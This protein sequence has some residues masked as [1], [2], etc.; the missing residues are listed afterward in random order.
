[1][2]LKKSNQLNILQMTIVILEQ[3]LIKIQI[4]GMKIMFLIIF[5]V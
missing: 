3:I 4:K 2:K 5:Y 1:M